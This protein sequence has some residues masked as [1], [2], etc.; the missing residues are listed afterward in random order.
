MTAGDL[1]IIITGK[2]TD[3]LAKDSLQ[4]S[5]KLIKPD[6]KVIGLSLVDYT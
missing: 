5:L 2:A 1:K 3:S 4:V 6:T